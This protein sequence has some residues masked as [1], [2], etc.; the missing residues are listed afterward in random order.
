MLTVCCVLVAG[1]VAGYSVDYVVRLEWMVRRYLARPFRFVCLTDGTRGQLPDPIETIRIPSSAAWV[2]VNGRGY[3][4]KLQLFNPAHGFTGRLLY[5][6]LDTLVVAPLDAIVDFP[7]SLALTAD[8]L[9]LE[10]AHLTSDR[11]G[12]RLHRRFNGSVMVWD[13]GT[14]HH[15]FTNFTP[16]VTWRL[17]TDQDWIGEQAIDAAGMPLAWFPRISQLVTDPG[18]AATGGPYP[19]DAKVVLTKK[20]KNHDAIARWPWFDAQWGGWRL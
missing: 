2:P 7:A 5:L 8:A 9:V 3:W 14:H 6:D 20:P 17:S 1:P 16:D 10:R 13:G 12:R 15:L 18:F 19:P 11:Y 4:A